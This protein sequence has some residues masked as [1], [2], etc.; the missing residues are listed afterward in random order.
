[1]NT[2]DTRRFGGISRL[3]GPEGFE[4]LAQASVTIVGVGGVG[5]WVA[6]A[7]ART[8]IGTITIIDGDTVEESNTNRQMPAM[9]GAYGRYKVDVL[10]ERLRKINPNARIN[11]LS[12][13]VN[14][15][16]FDD[17]IDRCD[18]LIDCIDSLSA[19]ALLLARGK[20]KAPVVLTSGGAGGKVDASLVSVADIA[21][22]EGDALIA[23]LRSQLRKKYGFAK[24]SASGKKATPLGIT[25]VYSREPVR[26]SQDEGEGFGVFMAVTATFAMRLVQLAVEGIL[27]EQKKQA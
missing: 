27:C 21:H 23:A 13:F 14:Q 17:V 25:A 1:M 8:A 6:E 22:V 26:P 18:V 19:K 10:S 16:N 7:I 15:D 5:S 4:K 11:A 24:G 20:E 9:D 2:S 3:F 12:V